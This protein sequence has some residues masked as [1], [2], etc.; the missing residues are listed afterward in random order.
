MYKV[1]DQGEGV[2]HR[3]IVYDHSTGATVYATDSPEIAHMVRERLED[4]R[5]VVCQ[6]CGAAHQSGHTCHICKR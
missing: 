2:S 4:G 3:H 1:L 6:D 5:W